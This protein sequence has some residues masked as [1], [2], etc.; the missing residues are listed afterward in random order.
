MATFAYE[1]KSTA[2][3][4]QNYFSSTSNIHGQLTRNSNDYNFFLPFR[5]TESYK[6]PSVIRVQKFGIHYH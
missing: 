5:R 3:T 2:I 6:I 1:V 4:F